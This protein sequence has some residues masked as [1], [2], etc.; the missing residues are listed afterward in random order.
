MSLFK[1]SSQ[2][3][4]QVID[5]TDRLAAEIPKGHAGTVHAFVKHTTVGLSTA[6]LDPGG[7]DLDYL[8]ALTQ[9]V[10]R[11]DFRHPHDPSHMPDHILASLVGP[12]V[13]VPVARGKLQL[14]TWQ[15]VVLFEFS[16][17]REREVVVTPLQHNLQ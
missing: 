12:S 11:L 9:M 3:S 2:E 15:R 1:I 5:I 14:G 7:T 4:K 6:D 16:G 8:D 17:P 13:T 10:P